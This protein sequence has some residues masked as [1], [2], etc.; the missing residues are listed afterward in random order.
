[1]WAIQF[2]RAVQ[3]MLNNNDE[4]ALSELFRKQDEAGQLMA[5]RHYDSKGST[6]DFKDAE[7]YNAETH[8]AGY[9][10]YF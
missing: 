7:L 10:F 6:F 4:E 5:G 2:T 3:R 8:N 9:V 1:M